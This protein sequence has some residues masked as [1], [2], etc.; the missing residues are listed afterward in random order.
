MR[1]EVSQ[2]K[3]NPYV[4]DVKLDGE[5]VSKYLRGL[6]IQIEAGEMPV[7]E[8]DLRCPESIVIDTDGEVKINIGNKKYKLTEVGQ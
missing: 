7:I 6:S 5:P 2:S 4:T 8:L 3:G 1:V